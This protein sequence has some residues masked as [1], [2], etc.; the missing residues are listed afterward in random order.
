MLSH[1]RVRRA[2]LGV[3]IQTRPM[4]ARLAAQVGSTDGN[5][6]A[7]G[8]DDEA[9][10]DGI[11][12][13]MADPQRRAEMGARGRELVAERYS[14]A[15]MVDAYERLYSELSR[16]RPRSRPPSPSRRP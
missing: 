11:I 14:G 8:A 4:P 3:S 12:E 16:A 10:A 1:G 5:V 7:Y 2:Y 9:L 13:L 15:A 6:Y